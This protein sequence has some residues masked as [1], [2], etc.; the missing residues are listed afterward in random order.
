VDT[1]KNYIYLQTKHEIKLVIKKN[2]KLNSPLCTFAVERLRNKCV[3]T[4]GGDQYVE[5][6]FTFNLC[7]YNISNIKNILINC[8]YWV[9][10]I[11]K[12]SKNVKDLY[13]SSSP[14][15]KVLPFLSNSQRCIYLLR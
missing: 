7:C 4:R 15:L 2:M 10:I 9:I 1:N 13:L 11:Y 6:I 12:L 14:A 5:S 3:F 8:K